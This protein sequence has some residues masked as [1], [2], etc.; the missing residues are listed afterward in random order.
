MG[1]K[2]NKNKNRDMWD[3]T[4]EEQE[5]MLREFD[6][7]IA[8]KNNDFIINKNN[9][10]ESDLFSMV[11]NRRGKNNYDNDEDDEPNDDFPEMFDFRKLSVSDTDED[12]IDDNDNSDNNSSDYAFVSHAPTREIVF[13][14]DNSLR[15]TFISDGLERIG[16]PVDSN[17]LPSNLE[18]GSLQTISNTFVN[19]VTYNMMPYAMV[20]DIDIILNEL[21][22]RN[23]GYYD[24]RRFK[25][26]YDESDEIY[27]LYIVSIESL[28]KFERLRPTL[29]EYQNLIVEANDRSRG[30]YNIANFYDSKYNDVKGFFD[31]IES[32]VNTVINDDRI[33][34][35]NLENNYIISLLD[36]FEV[37]KDVLVESDEDDDDEPIYDTSRKEYKDDDED[38]DDLFDDD[39]DKDITDEDIDELIKEPEKEIPLIYTK[40]VQ[41]E[42]SKPITVDVEELKK[43]IESS[44]IPPVDKVEVSLV[45]EDKPKE[46]IPVK[47]TTGNDLDFDDLGSIPV[48]RKPKKQ[49]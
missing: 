27:K 5:A 49:K 33:D 46:E 48:I 14:Y 16:L 32:D 10:F 22:K 7:F 4:Y 15:Y 2:K 42:E 39:D 47:D 17:R 6:D 31:V 36:I 35:R 19:F 25:I 20:D 29:K 28:E 26:I 40:P 43:N 45:V 41:K 9:D 44:A 18:V 3:L 12:D 23:I 13:E 30:E 1:K 11:E 24:N 38:F 37:V 21:S 8:G 34:T